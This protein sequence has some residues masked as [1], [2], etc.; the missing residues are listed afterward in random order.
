MDLGV[1][2]AQ[3][4]LQTGAYGLRRLQNTAG[5]SQGCQAAVPPAEEG[6][7]AEEGA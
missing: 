5:S 3:E 2:G 6:P 4:V 1:Q 7:S